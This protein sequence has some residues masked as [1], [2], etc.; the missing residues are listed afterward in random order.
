MISGFYKRVE[1]ISL[2]ISLQK[3]SSEYKDLMTALNLSEN[4]TDSFLEH[5]GLDFYYINK[6]IKWKNHDL[7]KFIFSQ[8]EIRK[9]AI[10]NS[11]QNQE[12]LFGH[13][14]E[15]PI[16]EWKVSG[17]DIKFL[18]KINLIVQD[19]LGNLTYYDNLSKIALEDMKK[20]KT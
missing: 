20:S 1:P 12:K 18:K 13:I 7:T 14:Q 6:W 15:K 17:N 8:K 10:R 19:D 11:F 2:K 5:F 4:E 9:S 16:N 3:N